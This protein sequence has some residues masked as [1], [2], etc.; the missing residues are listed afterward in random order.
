MV[1]NFR[2]LK[3]VHHNLALLRN[4]L[5]IS[6]NTDDQVNMLKEFFGLLQQLSVANMVHVEDAISIYSNWIVWI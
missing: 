2:T 6:R 1:E 4:S 5:F 3:L